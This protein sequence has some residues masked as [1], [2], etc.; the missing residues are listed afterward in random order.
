MKDEYRRMAKARPELR[1]D[2]FVRS[3]IHRE[4]AAEENAMM[5][6]M[7]QTP[8]RSGWITLLQ[9]RVS[10]RSAGN[11]HMKRRVYYDRRSGNVGESADKCEVPFRTARLRNGQTAAGWMYDG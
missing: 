7:S 11:Q 3:M 4:E 6:P 1:L 2:P 9:N 5:H 10:I 8:A